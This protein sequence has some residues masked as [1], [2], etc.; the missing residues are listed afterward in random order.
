[1]T[2]ELDLALSVLWTSNRDATYKA[3]RN[4]MNNERTKLCILEGAFRNE[5]KRV[6]QKRK[7]KAEEE[8]MVEEREERRKPPFQMPRFFYIQLKILQTHY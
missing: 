8:K 7:E 2:G 1:M 5:W 6:V 4:K 3:A